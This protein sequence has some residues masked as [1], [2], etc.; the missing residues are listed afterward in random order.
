MKLCFGIEELLFPDLLLSFPV[1][2][3]TLLD[4]APEDDLAKVFAGTKLG[5]N[6]G[7]LVPV[8]SQTIGDDAGCWRVYICLDHSRFYGVC[9]V[10]ENQGFGR[11]RRARGLRAPWGCH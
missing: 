6:V 5:A 4:R 8:S 3:I 7:V 9:T 10:V 1:H 11:W 2:K